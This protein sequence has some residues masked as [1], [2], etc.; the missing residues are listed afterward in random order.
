MVNERYAGSIFESFLEEEG[1]LTSCTAIALERVHDWQRK[2]GADHCAIAMADQP[3]DGD[4][5]A[6]TQASS[7]FCLR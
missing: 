1:M 7:P 2:E 5:H 3:R 4:D 6:E